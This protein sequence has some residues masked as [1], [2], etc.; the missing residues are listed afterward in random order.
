MVCSQRVERKLD[1][2]LD[3]SGF[4]ESCKGVGKR[5]REGRRRTTR[6]RQ[7]QA[8]IF[9]KPHCS[10]TISCPRIEIIRTAAPR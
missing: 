4:S 8:A 9:L 10:L 3:G 5:R 1:M 2:L 7:E 6:R